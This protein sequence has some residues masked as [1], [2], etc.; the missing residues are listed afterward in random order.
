MSVNRISK[1]FKPIAPQVSPKGFI[2]TALVFSCIAGG[3][4]IIYGA[5]TYHLFVHYG[6]YEPTILDMPPEKQRM[7]ALSAI[8][9]APVVESAVMVVLYEIA[10][11]LSNRVAVS[12]VISVSVSVLLHC[13]D[14]SLRGIMVMPCFALGIYGYAKYRLGPF[15]DSAL[16]PFLVHVIHNIPGVVVILSGALN[17]T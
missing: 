13:L 10:L 11:Y 2:K 17:R 9:L 1:K 7:V 8:I 5:V 6:L 15:G 4:S 12:M 16:I 3:A 14:G